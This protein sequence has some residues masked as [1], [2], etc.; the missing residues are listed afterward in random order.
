M[1]Q[2][3]HL[4]F[5]D[6]VK[7]NR[8]C[9]AKR[10]G[11]T[12]T[13]S[14]IISR[15]EK[16]RVTHVEG[17]VA[18]IV[19]DSGPCG[20]NWDSNINANNPFDVVRYNC[21]PVVGQTFRVLTDIGTSAGLPMFNMGVAGLP[22]AKSIRAGSQGVVKAITNEGLLVHIV[23]DLATTYALPMHS[24]HKLIEWDN[25]PPVSLDHPLPYYNAQPM[26]EV[27]ESS[28]RLCAKNEELIS[29]VE[30][31][32]RHF[33]QPLMFYVNGT[34]HDC[35]VESFNGADLATVRTCSG[36]RW[37]FRLCADGNWRRLMKLP[38]PAYLTT[39]DG[40]PLF[41]V[42]KDMDAVNGG[43]VLC[44]IDGE[45]T[46]GMIRSFNGVDTV[47]VEVK[48]GTAYD[49]QL[50]QGRW[51]LVGPSHSPSKVDVIET[52]KIKPV[53][54]E[55]QDGDPILG[56]DELRRNAGRW[57]AYIETAKGGV[58]CLFLVNCSDK[59]YPVFAEF[60]HNDETFYFIHDKVSDQW[61]QVSDRPEIKVVRPTA[62]DIK[63][64]QVLKRKAHPPLHDSFGDATAKALE[65]LQQ[66]EEY[67]QSMRTQVKEALLPQQTIKLGA[68]VF[69]VTG[70]CSLTPV[71]WDT[72]LVQA[73]KDLNNHKR[74]VVG[75][76]RVTG[77]ELSNGDVLYS[78]GTTERFKA[79]HLF[80]DRG[81]AADEAAKFNATWEIT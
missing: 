51:T 17:E 46:K 52:G 20:F 16:G 42:K 1:N 57:G 29:G 63:K 68:V 26:T 47:S 36:A 13:T 33:D 74:F 11:A 37:E 12:G 62:E 39:Q 54:L 30:A 23:G 78:F 76:L 73:L 43:L 5:G 58:K 14:L 77:A 24:L 72:D 15:G 59:T 49:F 22:G 56:V 18:H 28:V 66:D 60:L 70:I 4:K 21:I 53:Y 31:M 50:G 10:D 19:L 25:L 9:V 7:A 27:M 44:S 34:Q 67:K 2:N 79:Q 69:V 80:T 40:T 45:L 3:K 61:H 64:L 32:R 48:S 35:M 75:P 71:T 6:R 55:N 8:P 65:V 81:V 38:V 41:S